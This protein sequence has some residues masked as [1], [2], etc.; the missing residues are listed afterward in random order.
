M[1]PKSYWFA[2]IQL[3]KNHTLGLTFWS[4]YSIWER[5]VISEAIKLHF[6]DFINP[7]NFAIIF[8]IELTK[9]QYEDNLK[10]NKSTNLKVNF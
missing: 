9:E 3:D 5:S 6:K 7:D 2:T 8:I 10:I 1:N 4:K